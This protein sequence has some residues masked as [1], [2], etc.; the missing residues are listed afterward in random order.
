MTDYDPD[1]EPVAV[2]SG[3]PFPDITGDLGAY[4]PRVPKQNQPVSWE[5]Y[6]D[7][8][9][10]GV[11]DALM[12]MPFVSGSKEGAMS[13]LSDAFDREQPPEE[14]PNPNFSW[15]QQASLDQLTYAGDAL[16]STNLSEYLKKR[17][18]FLKYQRNQ[19]IKKLSP[20]AYA[21]GAI[22]GVALDPLTYVPFASGV[23]NISR[24]GAIGAGAYAQ[25]LNAARKDPMGNRNPEA[26]AL[27][28]MAGGYLIGGAFDTMKATAVGFKQHKNKVLMSSPEEIATD[29]AQSEARVNGIFAEDGKV[30]DANAPPPVAKSVGADVA[31][32]SDTSTF[33]ERL[34]GN[35]FV[36]TMLGKSMDFINPISRILGRSENSAKELMLNVFEVAPK[37]LKNTQKFG[38]Q[39]TESAL[40]TVSRRLHRGATGRVTTST[41]SL[42]GDMLKRLGEGKVRTFGAQVGLKPSVKAPTFLEFREKMSYR[43]RT[44]NDTG[45]PE[46]NKGADL[47]R[48]EFDTY[49]DE[50][51]ESGIVYDAQTR[52]I[53]NRKRDLEKSDEEL[54]A[55]RSG[56]G[57]IQ[58]P[59]NYL[60]KTRQNLMDEIDELH[61]QITRI[62]KGVEDGKKTYLNRVWRKDKI[63][64]NFDKFVRMIMKDVGLKRKDAEALARRL[65]DSKPYVHLMG[66][67][68][69]GTATP[70][71]QRELNMIND[72]DYAEFLEND[73]MNL[74]AIYSRTMRPDLELY[75][76]FGSVDLEDFNVNT[77]GFGPI[78]SVKNNYEAR[79]KAA[80]NEKSRKELIKERDENIEDLLAMRDL[81]RGTYMIPADPNSMVSRGIRIAKNYNAM[82][83]LTG[84]MAAA[85]DIGRLVTANGL[86]KSMGS[87]FEALYKNRKLYKMGRAEAQSVGESFEFWLN[88]RAAQMAD[89]G[90]SYGFHNRFEKFA[91]GLSHANFMVNG[92]SMWNDFVKASTSV[93]V[94]TKILTDVEAVM[95]GTASAKQKERLA[96]S[97]IGKAE[98]ESIYAMKDKWYRSENNVFGQAESWDN[99]IAKEAFQN[100][101]SKEIN[102]IIVTP[103]LGDRPLF[104]SNQYMSLIGQ[105]K[106]FAFG[107]H[108][109]VLM[110][111]LQAMDKDTAVQIAMMVAIG[112][113][114]AE[115]RNTQLNG[116]DMSFNDYLL[117]GT[118]RSGVTG[119]IMDADSFLASTTGLGI[120]ST[121][122]DTIPPSQ[123]SMLEAVAGPSARSVM[124]AANVAGDMLTFNADSQTR[125]DFS[126][127]VPMSNIAHIDAI[128]S[129]IA[130]D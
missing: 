30:I 29:I 98:T 79:L 81:I 57:E 69:T 84:A 102:T 89:L 17:D 33:A 26:V 38:Y 28:T 24:V 12:G 64:A 119:L 41:H 53:M 36:P 21:I 80:K 44:G 88:H 111:A 32:A 93:V 108:M 107:S 106:S 5:R 100:A 52:G 51:L 82:T 129:A 105:F 63:D 70:L 10:M 87:L 42:Y 73:A 121:F 39:A 49:A 86:R 78:Q 116:P 72:N 31:E 126:S 6:K 113:V 117:Q 112:G 40:E 120:Q 71:H 62:R 122:G 2:P 45:F 27:L 68:K 11:T 124:T 90:D 3:N 83:M 60:N 115:I 37:L 114:V 23:K 25:E 65:R 125:D 9:T 99:Q 128:Y 22:G 16:E 56:Q 59:Q 58:N 104:M 13:L 96:V 43:L 92:M 20:H 130:G 91:E 110:P 19:E 46:I 54:L 97:G 4:T 1:A 94:S 15:Q 127:L 61:E 14:A 76:R 101:I 77:N 67:S 123:K 109:R 34:Q 35:A 50:I 74:F 75:K 118:V 95:R 85:P 18:G 103:G 47:I 8:L 55:A 66:E 7:I 48:K